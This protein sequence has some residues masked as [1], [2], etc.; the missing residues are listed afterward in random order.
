MSKTVLFQ[1]IQFSNG[2][3]FGSILSIDSTL[4]GVTTLGQNGHENNSNKEPF[5]K[6]G[7]GNSPSDCFL[8]YP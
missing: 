3:Q 7:T 8:S 5:F 1:T 2:T 4:L 6:A